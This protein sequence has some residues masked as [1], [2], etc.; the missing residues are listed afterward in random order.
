MARWLRKTILPELLGVSPESFT[1]KAFWYATD[2]VVSEREPQESRAGKEEEE[3]LFVGLEDPVFIAIE[4]DLF[5]RIDD[6]MG[7]SPRVICYDTT[8]PYTYIE[9]PKR[10]AAM[11]NIPQ[12]QRP[13]RAGK[14]IP[15]S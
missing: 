13:R 4:A 15:E 8:N 7:L 1:S 11:K 5:R 12:S 2:D 14:D 3:D 10:S 9:E 6:L